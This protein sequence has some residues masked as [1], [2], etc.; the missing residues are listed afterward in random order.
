MFFYDF[1]PSDVAV[2]E[3]SI[4]KYGSEYPIANFNFSSNILLNLNLHAYN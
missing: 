3:A 2:I 4:L 1:A